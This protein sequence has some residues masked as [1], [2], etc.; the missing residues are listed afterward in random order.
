[1]ERTEL[2][3]LMD[4]YKRE[5]LE[6]SKRNSGRSYSDSNA[7]TPSELDERE[8]QMADALENNTPFE[9]DRSN[10]LPEFQPREQMITEE[11]NNQINEETPQAVPAQVTMPSIEDRASANE[12]VD[13]VSNLRAN[14]ARISADSNASAEQK[15]RCR[16]IN[17]FLTENSET[18]TLRA[19][20]F[21]AD[22]AFGISSARV[23]IFLP[24]ASGNVTLFDGL[25]NVDGISDN[26]RLPAPP[27]ELAMSPQASGASKLPYADYTVY[28]EHP[29]YVRAVFT[30]VPVFSGIESVQPVRMLAKSVGT[31]E[32][33]PIVVDESARNQL[34]N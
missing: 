24:L 1:M 9:R 4:R 27:R 33:E 16:D 7:E 23:M 21:A 26:V 15:E 5:M 10:P 13:V 32:P 14:C 28:V 29:D 11:A 19:E 31:E 30:N 34:R 20:T 22:R 6:F 25:T 3:L 2:E 18:G 12:A 8:Q 17:D